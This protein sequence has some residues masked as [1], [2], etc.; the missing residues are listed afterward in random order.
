M[1]RAQAF[2]LFGMAFRFVSKVSSKKLN[3]NTAMHRP[4]PLSTRS[5][6]KIYAHFQRDNDDPRGV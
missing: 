2:F 1:S 5:L 3:I 4:K 6:L